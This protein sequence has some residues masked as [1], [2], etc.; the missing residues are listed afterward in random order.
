MGSWPTK[1]NLGQNNVLIE[2]IEING[3]YDKG[4]FINYVTKKVGLSY[5]NTKRE[6]FDPILLEP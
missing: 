5:S 2:S 6:S 3:G 1:C 4:L